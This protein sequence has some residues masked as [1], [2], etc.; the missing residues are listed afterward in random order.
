MIVFLV[1]RK[2]LERS[3]KL[4]NRTLSVNHI[5]YY[6]IIVLKQYRPTLVENARFTA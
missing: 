5:V 2:N 3:F 6:Q 4:T 1:C